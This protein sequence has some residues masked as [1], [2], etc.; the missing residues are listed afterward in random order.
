MFG[1]NMSNVLCQRRSGTVS[2]ECIH[3]K[4]ITEVTRAVSEKKE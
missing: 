3:M 2:M 1:L 4:K